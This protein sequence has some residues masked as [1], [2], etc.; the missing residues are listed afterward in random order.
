MEICSWDDLQNFCTNAAEELNEM[1]QT[2][3]D[4]MSMSPFSIPASGGT[5]INNIIDTV[6]GV[7][8]GTA[9]T[10]C[11]LFFLMEFAKKSMDLQW[12][13]WGFS[14]QKHT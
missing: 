13:K 2:C 9:M 7:I 3:I 6:I 12:V 5:S 11:V 10:L 14:K 4:L 8:S 1:F